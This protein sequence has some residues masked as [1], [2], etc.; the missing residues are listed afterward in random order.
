MPADE[1]ITSFADRLADLAEPVRRQRPQQWS[2][3]IEA[4]N[5]CEKV[6]QAVFHH[7]PTPR[8]EI[9]RQKALAAGLKKP[10]QRKPLW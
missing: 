2:R 3:A 1:T 5:R 6:I 9:L 4:L 7:S 8:G 10:P